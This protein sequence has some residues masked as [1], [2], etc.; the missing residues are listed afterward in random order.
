[1]DIGL[2][3]K[4]AGVGFLVSV[5][6][7]VLSRTGRDEQVTLVSLAGVIIV[8]LI[9]TPQLGELFDTIKGVFGI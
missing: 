6:C 2:I 1:M 3:L 9:L 8:L 7:Q 5:A 4:V